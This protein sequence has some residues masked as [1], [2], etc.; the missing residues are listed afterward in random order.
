MRVHFQGAV[1]KHG[2]P[3]DLASE[4]FIGAFMYQSLWYGA[5]YVVVE[6]WRELRLSDPE[7]EFV[8]S[9]EAMVDLL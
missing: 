5:L 7:V 9:D 3:T 6:G 4:A 1:A 2:V 8:L